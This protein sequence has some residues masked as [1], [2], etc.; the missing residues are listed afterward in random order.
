MPKRKVPDTRFPDAVAVS[1]NRAIKKMVNEIGKETLTL[2]D[3]YIAPEI[4]RDRRDGQEFLVDGLSENIKKMFKTLKEKA[5]NVFSSS[6][7]EKT[8]QTYMKNLDNFNKN[9]IKQQGKVIGVGPT[10]TDP[11]LQKYLKEKTADN[12]A[13]ITKLEDDYL[14]KVVEIVTDGVEKGSTAKQI[15]KQL[16]ERVEMSENRA[17]FI[18]VDQTGSIFGQMTAQRHQ[19]MGV[20]RF[21]WRTSKDERVRESHMLL[22]DKVFSYDDP[23]QVGA[24]K[25]LPG[26]D[27]RC[28]CIPI[29]VFDDEDDETVSEETKLNDDETR[30]INQYISSDSYKINDK[31]RRNVPL[32][33]NDK[34]L[35]KNLDKALDKLPKYEGDLNR[36]LFFYDDNSLEEYLKGFDIGNIISEASYI[37]TSRSVY[38]NDDDVRL[39][40]KNSKSGIDLKGYNDTEQEVLY[41]RSSKFI[42]IDKRIENG[43]FFIILEEYDE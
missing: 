34:I 24:R 43:K 4:V 13:Y 39:I 37:S 1:Y 35:I 6:R 20:N 2:F 19:D 28:R 15:R 38:D 41:K 16:V 36:S 26:E 11:K 12:V 30:A 18:A 10:E 8:V 29:P 14:K 23:P 9:I 32:D 5:A 33:E 31:L 42:V 7:K 22:S 3:Q 25:V 21:K 17:Q 40:I 27:Y